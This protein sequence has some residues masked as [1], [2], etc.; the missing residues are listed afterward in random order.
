M[1]VEFIKSGVGGFFKGRNPNVSFEEL[2][3]NYLASS[4]VVY[5]GKAGSILGNAITF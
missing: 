2:K 1:N 3:S 5:I 4:Q